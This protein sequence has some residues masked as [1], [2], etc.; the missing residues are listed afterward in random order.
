MPHPLPTAELPKKLQSMFADAR[1]AV[2]GWQPDDDDDDPIL[3]STKEWLLR[4]SR[5]EYDDRQYWECAAEDCEEEGDWLGAIDAYRKV[6]ELPKLSSI[7]VARAHK[8]IGFLQ[9]LLG[10][11]RAALKSYQTA[12]ANVRNDVPALQRTFIGN[13]IA[14]LLHMGRVRRAQKL[15]Q[16]ELT[17]HNPESPNYLGMALLLIRS[18][19]CDLARRRLV[20]ARQSLDCATAWLDA[21]LESF[22]SVSGDPDI[23]AGIRTAQVVWWFMEASR[24]RLAGEGEAEIEAMQR[25]IAE[26]RLCFDAHGWQA[27]WDDLRLMIGLEKIAD[28]YDRQGK[29]AEAATARAEANDIFVRRRYPEAARYEGRSHI[30]KH[31]LR[32]WSIF[33]RN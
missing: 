25:A 4:L 24:R 17:R 12:V 5:G 15:V 6:V 27:V 20:E 11:E 9:S 7:Y 19:Q 30:G 21:S 2:D 14:Q 8:S 16:Q 10:D 23:P 26:S 22:R 13:E 28:A 32:R 18:A 33:R 3:R 1:A 29:P 31:R